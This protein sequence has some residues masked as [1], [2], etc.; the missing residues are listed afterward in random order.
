MYFII[1]WNALYFMIYDGTREKYN[2]NPS[3]VLNS[4]Y[5]IIHRSKSQFMEAHLHQKQQPSMNKPSMLS[6]LI[7]KTL[8]NLDQPSKQKALQYVTSVHLS[9][10]YLGSFPSSNTKYAVLS[11]F[12][13][14]K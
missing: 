3:I 11:K 4:H 14:E 5:E 10:T 7:N 1:K 6:M 12:S 8:Y 9:F 13:T 2:Y